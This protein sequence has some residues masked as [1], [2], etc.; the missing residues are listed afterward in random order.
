[1][2]VRGDNVDQVNHR[3]RDIRI[4]DQDRT[5]RD[6]KVVIQQLF[7]VIDDHCIELTSKSPR[8]NIPFIE[9]REGCEVRVST[10]DPVLLSARNE[11]GQEDFHDVLKLCLM[12]H[13]RDQ[14]D[15]FPLGF[16]VE[17]VIRDTISNVFATYA[18]S[19]TSR[20]KSR[21]TCHYH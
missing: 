7:F 1:M 8:S 4:R 21:P 10:I 9:R 6:T 11:V 5:H 17:R 16:G 20:S 14:G 18:R 3:P 19:C 2:L 15:M 12:T 13:A